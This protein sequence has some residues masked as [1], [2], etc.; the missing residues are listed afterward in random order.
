M[1]K[2]NY[3]GRNY[4]VH[5]EHTIG[6]STTAYITIGG[7]RIYSRTCPYRFEQAATESL[8]EIIAAR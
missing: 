8:I 4:T 7:R 6:Q 3:K 2:I 1:T 5:F